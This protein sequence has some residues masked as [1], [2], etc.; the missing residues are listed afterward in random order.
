MTTQPQPP[1]AVTP[2]LPTRRNAELV[3]LCFAAVIIV[4]AL[5]IVQASQGRGL[6]WDLSGYGLAFLALFGGA[7]L[8]VRRFAPCADP[9]LLPVAALLNGLGLVM[10]HRLDI[11]DGAAGVGTHSSAHQQM[12]WTLIGVAAF[13]VTVA[14]LKDHRRLARYGYTCGLAGLVILAVPALLPASFSEHNGAKIWIR[15][16]GFSIQPAEFSKILLLIFF[17]AVLVAKRGLFTSAGIH[18]MGI[19]VPRPRDL[20]PLLAAWVLAVGVMVFEKDLGTSLLLYAS[21]LVVVY[22]AT[23]RLSWIV[24]GLALFAAGSVVAYHIFGHVR[25]RVQTWLHPFADPEGSSYQIVQS[26]FSFA[27]GG[28]FGTGLGNGQPDTV[29]AAST[30]FIIA[31]FGEELGL[32]GLSGLLML[33][34]ILIVRGLRAAIAIR[35]SFGKLLAGGLASTLAIQLFIVV[36]GVTKLVPLTGLTTPWL[37]YGGSSLLAN[38]LLLAILVRISHAARRPLGTRARDTV[39]L[40]VTDT[41]VI[42]RA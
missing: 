24:I 41:E 37:S 40:A 39:P 3:L 30:D 27:T 5:L 19:T 42:R 1:V 38:Y 13:A 35:D 28:I 25:V 15:F 16:P 12:L 4:A 36:G 20:A 6:R 23:Q 7:H 14:L 34:T 26:L 8:A 10:I 33:Y 11:A 9:L 29:P 31:A 32:V 2:A 18:V 22:L 17:S 21:F